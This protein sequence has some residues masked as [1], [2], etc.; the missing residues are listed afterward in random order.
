MKKLLAMALALVL[1]I[2]CL[3]GCGGKDGGTTTAPAGEATTA[4]QD[5]ASGETEAGGSAAAPSGT[6]D[7]NQFEDDD[8]GVCLNWRRIRTGISLSPAH[9]TCVRVSWRRP[10]II[11]SSSSSFMTRQ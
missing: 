4:A 3:A 1:G 2:S 11:R 7:L 6:I 9:R 10:A 5:T 8:I